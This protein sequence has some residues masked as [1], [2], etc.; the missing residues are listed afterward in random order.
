MLHSA[1]VMFLWFHSM[2]QEDEEDGDDDDVKKLQCNLHSVFS[3]S[4]FMKVF[5]YCLL[6]MCHNI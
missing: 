5:L 4:G 6:Y 2:F 1:E 3:H